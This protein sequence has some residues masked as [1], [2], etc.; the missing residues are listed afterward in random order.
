MEEFVGERVNGRSQKVEGRSQ[1][2]IRAKAKNFRITNVRRFSYLLIKFSR[3]G[4]IGI[5]DGK[6][7]FI[8]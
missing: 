5:V 7:F 2:S 8:L 6:F 1:K 4:F 3:F